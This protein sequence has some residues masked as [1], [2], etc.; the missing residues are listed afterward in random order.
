MCFTVA[1]YASLCTDRKKFAIIF[2]IDYVWM[3]YLTGRISNTKIN[4]IDTIEQLSRGTSIRNNSSDRG[5]GLAG[6]TKDE[7]TTYIRPFARLY[8]LSIGRCCW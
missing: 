5:R 7:D 3:R 6:T 8:S 1:Y 4:V 2:S